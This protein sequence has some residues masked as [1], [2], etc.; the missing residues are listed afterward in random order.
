LSVR[1]TMIHSAQDGLRSALV[2][3]SA[4]QSCTAKSAAR[5]RMISI[6]GSTRAGS[7]SASSGCTDPAADLTVTTSTA[8]CTGISGSSCMTVTMSYPYRNDAVVGIPGFNSLVPSTITISVTER[9][10]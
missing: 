9:L 10:S 1:E 3:A 5:S 8:T 4:D 2:A 6:I 7:E